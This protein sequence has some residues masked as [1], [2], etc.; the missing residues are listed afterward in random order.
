MVS[1]WIWRSR[2]R[3]L[4]RVAAVLGCA[5]A[6]GGEFHGMVSFGWRPKLIWWWCI[7]AAWRMGGPSA[8]VD[9][10][11]VD[12]AVMDMISSDR[13]GRAESLPARTSRPGEVQS[14]DAMSRMGLETSG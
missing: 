3:R 1:R 12:A 7:D 10:L 2:E 11:P 6:R 13:L 4:L 8:C 14:S 9:S 5:A